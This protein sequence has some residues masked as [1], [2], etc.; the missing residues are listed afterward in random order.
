LEPGNY[1]RK[2][3]FRAAVIP[4]AASLKDKR[5]FVVVCVLAGGMDAAFFTP[6]V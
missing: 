6:A 1:C 4:G 2:D 5:I 3:T